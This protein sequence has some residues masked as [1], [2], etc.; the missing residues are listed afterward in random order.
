LNTHA[1]FTPPT[2]EGTL[3]TPGL[4]GGGE[5]GGAAWDPETRML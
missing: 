5:W 1:R 4:D 2:L 3:V